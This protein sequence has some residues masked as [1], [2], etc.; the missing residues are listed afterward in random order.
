MKNGT[1]KVL[2][3]EINETSEMLCIHGNRKG[4]EELK[5]YIDKLL[6]TKSVPE[7]SHLMTTEWGGNELTSDKQSESDKL[8]HHVKMFLW[9]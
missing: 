2:T 3:F 5:T 6:A 9:K 4:L 7:H 1:E 8:I